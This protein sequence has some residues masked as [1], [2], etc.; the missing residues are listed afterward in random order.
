MRRMFENT[1]RTMAVALFALVILGSTTTAAHAQTQRKEEV[2]TFRVPIKLTQ[3]APDIDGVRLRCWIEAPS[4]ATL[5]PAGFHAKIPITN[6][7]LDTTVVGNVRVDLAATDIGKTGT[8]HC[9]MSP[10]LE[11]SPTDEFSE[12]SRYFSFRTTPGLPRIT[13]TFTW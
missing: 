5:I 6:A 9:E 1:A 2:F 11:G 3:L 7:Q 8:Y 12:Q 10:R 13:G 4:S